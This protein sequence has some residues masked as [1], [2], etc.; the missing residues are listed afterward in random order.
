LPRSGWQWLYG[1]RRA[2]A[3]KP[4]GYTVRVLH[5]DALM[6]ERRRNAAE[7]R[8]KAANFS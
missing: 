3:G 2:L 5:P 1:L 6:S 7:L 8:P 4:H